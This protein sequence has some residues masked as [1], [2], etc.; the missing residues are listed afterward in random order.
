MNSFDG[1]LLVWSPFYGKINTFN[2]IIYF[3]WSFCLGAGEIKTESNHESVVTAN[4][5]TEYKKE[6]HTA[7]L[8]KTA[9]MVH[10]NKNLGVQ[11]EYFNS[12]YKGMGP[13][14]L[15]GEKIEHSGDIIL[16]LCV[17]F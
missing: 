13:N 4:R 17:S 15:V 8:A 12:S 5:Q 16:S 11:L 7:V 6:K 14:P 2:K 3:D 9:L 1:G 10:L